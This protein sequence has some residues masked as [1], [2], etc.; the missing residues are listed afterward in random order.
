MLEAIDML[1]VD[2]VVPN[3]VLILRGRRPLI[4]VIVFG[5]ADPP[6]AR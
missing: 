4:F 6:G 2:R 1:K 5:E 3:A